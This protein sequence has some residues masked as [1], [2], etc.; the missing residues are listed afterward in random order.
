MEVSNNERNGPPISISVCQQQN[1][2]VIIIRVINC[3]Y[4]G[5]LELNYCEESIKVR[6]NITLAMNY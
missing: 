6:K 5:N 1:V 4:M 3:G 2:I